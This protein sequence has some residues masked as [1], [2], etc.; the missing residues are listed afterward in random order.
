MV[1]VLPY[2]VKKITFFQ[3]LYLLKSKVMYII[4]YFRAQNALYE[5]FKKLTLLLWST[6]AIPIND[7]FLADILKHKVSNCS[8]WT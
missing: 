8:A 7:H 4:Q 2:I 5:D 1:S 6:V 3:T